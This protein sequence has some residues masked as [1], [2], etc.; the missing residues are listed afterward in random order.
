MFTERKTKKR[1]GRCYKVKK[2]GGGRLGKPGDHK[3]EEVGAWLG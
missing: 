3:W 2:G 1:G